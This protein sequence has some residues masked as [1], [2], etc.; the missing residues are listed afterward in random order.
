MSTYRPTLILDILLPSGLKVIM[1]TF[2]ESLTTNLSL[3]LGEFTLQFGLE[4]HRDKRGQ[5][6][7][8]VNRIHLI[9]LGLPTSLNSVH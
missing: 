9:F 6:G 8:R 3:S 2:R 4:V 7:A 5:A 1:S